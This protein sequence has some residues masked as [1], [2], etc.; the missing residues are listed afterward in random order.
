MQIK[1]KHSVYQH[2]TRFNF[3]DAI[4]YVFRNGVGCH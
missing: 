4:P 2:F 1:K 3:D